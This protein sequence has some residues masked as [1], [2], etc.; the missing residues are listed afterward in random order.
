[1]S[2]LGKTN[3]ANFLK[4][5]AEAEA[6]EA[7]EAAARAAAEAANPT[8]PGL[9][10]QVCGAVGNCFRTTKKAGGRYRNRNRGRGR[11]ATRRNRQRR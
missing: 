10:Q 3:H 9:L 4:L 6:A 1:M 5:V 2:L 7:K 8:K 11:R